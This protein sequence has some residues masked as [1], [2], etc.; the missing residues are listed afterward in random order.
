MSTPRSFIIIAI[1]FPLWNLISIAERDQGGNGLSDPDRC[2][3]YLAM[4]LYPCAAG[5]G[6]VALGLIAVHPKR[7][8]QSSPRARRISNHLRTFSLCC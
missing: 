7:E 1:L 2:N 4:V 3:R 5:Q 6:T 8:Y